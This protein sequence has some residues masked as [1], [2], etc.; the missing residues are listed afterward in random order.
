MSKQEVQVELTGT[1]VMLDIVPEVK[2]A[3][4]KAVANA[5]ESPI[6][7]WVD[8]RKNAE[9]FTLRVIGE[10]S[11][12]NE[13]YVIDG[14]PTTKGLREWIRTFCEVVESY[15]IPGVCVGIPAELPEHALRGASCAWRLKIELPNGRTELYGGAADAFPDN[16]KGKFRA[17]PTAMA[18]TRSEGRALVRALSLRCIT[19]DEVAGTQAT[20]LDEEDLAPASQIQWDKFDNNFKEYNISAA[21]FFNFAAK[22]AN[23]KPKR[24][25]DLNKSQAVACFELLN[26]YKQGETVPQDMLGYDKSWKEKLNG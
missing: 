22:T 2:K 7:P 12:L 3:V 24:V 9:E 20:D 17:F 11:A 25:R 5:L 14:K 13:S 26:K 6:T 19:Y 23:I 8:P 16:L 15:S 10:L 21:K 1:D 18:E 4:K